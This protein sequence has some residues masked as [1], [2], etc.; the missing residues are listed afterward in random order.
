MVGRGRLARRLG[1][2]ASGVPYHGRLQLA[3]AVDC[4]G[5]GGPVDSISMHV[6]QCADAESPMQAG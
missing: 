6:A 5:A 1:P 4:S 2:D 3:Q